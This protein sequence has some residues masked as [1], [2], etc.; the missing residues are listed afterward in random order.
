MFTDDFNS[1]GTLASETCPRCRS[2]GLAV[3]SDETYASA[4]Q[5]DRFIEKVVVCPSIT[6]WCPAC[7]LVGNW[8]A[9]RWEPEENPKGKR[10][11][12]SEIAQG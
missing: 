11:R 6:A 2:V 10:L 12:L 7:G 1:A 4:S 3:P 5:E 9:M 8:P